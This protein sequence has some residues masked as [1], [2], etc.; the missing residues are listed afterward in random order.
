MRPIQLWHPSNRAQSSLRCSLC[1]D[2]FRQVLA[3]MGT[4]IIKRFRVLVLL[5]VLS[6]CPGTSDASCLMSHDYSSQEV[7]SFHQFCDLP[8]Q[9]CYC[10]LVPTQSSRAKFH[11]QSSLQSLF[12]KDCYLALLRSLSFYDTLIGRLLAQFMVNQVTLIPHL[13]QDLN[14][15]QAIVIIFKCQSVRIHHF[16]SKVSLSSQSSM[17]IYYELIAQQL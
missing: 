4:S 3:F 10:S 2:S 12:G 14:C 17:F 9:C 11:A 16:G 6:K 5:M 13:K 1:K 15:R 8:M 7:F